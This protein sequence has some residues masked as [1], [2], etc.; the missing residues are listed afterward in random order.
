[1]SALDKA[2]RQID[3]RR[4]ALHGQ[5]ER[6]SEFA[7]PVE[8]VRPK[9][10]VWMPV[11]LVVLSLALVGSWV[12][13][14]AL[15]PDGPKSMPR[16]LSLGGSGQ[17]MPKPDA[18]EPSL[19]P[20]MPASAQALASAPTPAPAGMSVPPL[21]AVGAPLGAVASQPSPESALASAADP[22][23][24]PWPLWHVAGARYWGWGV[25]DEGARLWLNALKTEDPKTAL[26]LIA[27]QQNLVQADI[28]YKR[29]SKDMPVVVLARQSGA[30]KLWVVLA[31]PAAADLERARQRLSAG[32]SVAVA[33][34]TWAQWQQA[35]SGAALPPSGSA[36]VTPVPSALPAA[37]SVPTTTPA[38]VQSVVPRMPQPALP[39]PP[40]PS[41]APSPSAGPLAAPALVAAPSAV[42]SAA[43]RVAAPVPSS[44]ASINLNPA[45]LAFAANMK[46]SVVVT[47]SA[48]AAS[49]ASAAAQ[50]PTS[51]SPA[52]NSPAP[53]ARQAA[54][55]D[56][57]AADAPQLSRTEAE[58]LPTSG[59]V[60][61]AAKAID[62]D[63]QAIEKSLGRGD[64]Q[65]AL[66]AVG[67]LEKYIGENWR[68]QY[69]SGVALMGLGRWDAAITA[70]GKAQTL[71]PRHAMAALYL[72]VAL[73]ER[74]EHGRAVQVLDKAQQVQPLSP[75]LWLN[76][77]HSYQALGQKAEARKA[78]TRFLDLSANRPDLAPQRTWVQNR[79]QKDNG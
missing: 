74:G 39:A 16:W 79:L 45:G 76:Q 75:E 7:Y 78:Y 18:A 64:H 15:L 34:N 35:L 73:Q 56:E 49:T 29:W 25:W 46:P 8:Y 36:V 44:V 43:A 9:R 3:E 33:V 28:L 26:L 40:A 57:V 41:V 65:G 77:A 62:V 37:A 47:H 67:K 54:D 1:M 31:V 63:F 68:T 52:P 24:S 48:G 2:L 66:E 50:V 38:P 32:L 11:A 22:N 12:I 14:A 55:G 51:N 20:P 27:D 19:K 17:G 23:K 70:L 42:A 4:T 21:A 5:D 61:M 53:R 60:S 30:Q 69:L 71:N 72:S 58:R 59:P 10:S 6:L 13:M